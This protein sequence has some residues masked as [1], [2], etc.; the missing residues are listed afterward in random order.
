M[1]PSNY[2]SP[3]LP[4]IEYLYTTVDKSLYRNFILNFGMTEIHTDKGLF[5]KNL[6]K[7]KYLQYRESIQT[8]S[9]LEEKD[10]LSGKEICN[11][12]LIL[13]NTIFIQ[14]RTYTK[15]AEIFSQMGGYMQLM[16]TT[17]SLISLIIN[18]FDS[19]LKIINSIFNFSLQKKKMA[20]KYQS[21]RDFDFIN[22]P[23][24]KKN[25]IFTSRKS[26]KDL[27]NLDCKNNNNL[28]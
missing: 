23:I 9:F 21:L 5:N 18:K 3:I 6:E 19:E 13:E 4:K 2:S 10:Y 8:F 14:K 7:K 25:L 12:Q 15:I 16:H 26:V 11:V 22:I 20:L 24:Y 28:I 17:F 1:N 27:K